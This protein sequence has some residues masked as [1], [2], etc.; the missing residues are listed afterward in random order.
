MI[1]LDWNWKAWGLGGYIEHAT[2]WATFPA[3]TKGELW[4]GPLTITGIWEQHK[5][6]TWRENKRR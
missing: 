1:W 6:A 4:I 5:E 2:A 3:L